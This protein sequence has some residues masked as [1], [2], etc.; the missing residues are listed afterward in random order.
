MSTAK[1][2]HLEFIQGVITRMAKCSFMIKG[3]A[4]AIATAGI[5]LLSKQEIRF[6]YCFPVFILIIGLWALD[7]FFLSQERMYRALYNK[8]RKEDNTDFDMNASVFNTGKNSWVCST[9]SKTLLLFYGI[10][11]AAVIIFFIIATIKC[12]IEF[13]I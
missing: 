9:F 4:I 3:W 13:I 1:E 10:I 7:G 11:F 8:V 6:L 5:T 2:K 12:K